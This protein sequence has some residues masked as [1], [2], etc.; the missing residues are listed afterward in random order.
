MFAYFLHILQLEDIEQ[1][2]QACLFLKCLKFSE[3]NESFF[4]LFKCILRTCEGE[5]KFHVCAFKRVNA[6]RPCHLQGCDCN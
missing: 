5:K 2:K 4:L 1:W 3:Q 6:L